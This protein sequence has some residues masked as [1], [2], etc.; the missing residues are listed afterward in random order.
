MK[1]ILYLFLV[2]LCF[3]LP[4]QKTIK[5]LTGSASVIYKSDQKTIYKLEDS[6]NSIIG[7]FEVFRTSENQ[8]VNLTYFPVRKG[9]Y[10]LELYKDGR[11]I[12]S[13][14]ITGTWSDVLPNTIWELI[15]HCFSLTFDDPNCGGFS[16]HIGC[17]RAVLFD[18]VT[19][20]Y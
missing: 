14:S 7:N 19:I 11:K 12:D 3:N 8:N 16:F 10:R 13:K 20:S 1:I 6:K 9:S 4:A 17:H 2:F 18:T 15:S 5:S